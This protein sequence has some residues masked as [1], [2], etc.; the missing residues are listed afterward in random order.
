MIKAATK[1]LFA[2]LCCCALCLGL[3]PVQAFAPT[4]AFAEESTTVRALEMGSEAIWPGNKVYFGENNLGFELNGQMVWTLY[5]RTGNGNATYEDSSGQQVNENDALTIYQDHD[6]W[7][8]PRTVVK[9]EY[10]EVRDYLH[11]EFSERFNDVEW[12]SLLKTTKGSSEYLDNVGFRNANPSNMT[13]RDDGLDG[14][15]MFPLSLEELRAFTDWFP[16]LGS[17]YFAYTLRSIDIYSGGVCIIEKFNSDDISVDSITVD[18]AIRP[19]CNLNKNAILL[20]SNPAND[21]ASTEKGVLS[22]ISSYGVGSWKLTLLDSSRN[23]FSANVEGEA[24]VIAG[25][26]IRVSYSGAQTGKDEYVTALLCDADGDAICWVTLAQN[27]ESGTEWLS[28]PRDVSPGTYTLKVFSEHRSG[29]YKSDYTSEPQEITREC[30][31]AERI[32][33]T[34]DIHRYG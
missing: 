11:S 32:Y 26:R 2:F 3:I 9:K 33:A 18:N 7:E 13:F 31:A 14:D 12:D 6:I 22:N 17:W 34:G 24:S 30:Y 28:V 19:A 1:K 21:T 8:G 20:V 29:N 23:G 27:S 16:M 5:F 15:V 4:Q 10:W 25:D